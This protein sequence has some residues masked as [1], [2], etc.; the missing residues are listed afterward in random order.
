M[1]IN[2]ITVLLTAF[3]LLIG[4]SIYAQN[5]PTEMVGRFF[6]EYQNEGVSE[7]LDNLY[8]TNKWMER[9]QDAISNLKSQMQGLNE[10]YVGK[11]YGYELIVEKKLSESYL[12]LS[13]LVKYDRQPLRF[14]FQFYMPDQNWIVYSFKY[15]GNIDDEIEEA[16]KL[17]YLNLGN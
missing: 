15:D 11:F 12:L 1:K 2:Q 3:L 16:A 14:T 17:Y 13:Y 6:E 8:G 4:T 5:T 7:A 9:N 10:D